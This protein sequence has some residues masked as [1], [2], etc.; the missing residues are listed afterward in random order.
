MDARSTKEVKQRNHRSF[1]L[2][3]NIKLVIESLCREETIPA[4]DSGITEMIIPGLIRRGLMMRKRDRKNEKFMNAVMKVFLHHITE[5]EFSIEDFS[6]LLGISRAHLHRKLKSLTGK[7]PSQYVRSF[8][9]SI[10]KEM[11]TGNKGT[12]SEIAYSVGFSSPV[13]FSKCFKD[14]F[15]L[16]PSKLCNTLFATVPFFY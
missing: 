3:Q 7:S 4:Q 6:T 1:A 15:G 9:L 13:Y 14:E 5:N 2:E 8:R 12:I 11:I 10:A 16:P